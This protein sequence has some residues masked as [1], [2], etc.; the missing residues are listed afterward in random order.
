VNVNK[1]LTR[2][3]V[4]MDTWSSGKNKPNSN[5]IKDN[6]MPKQTQYKPKQS[7]FQRQKNRF[8]LT[9]Q[10]FFYSMDVLETTIYNRLLFSS[11]TKRNRRFHGKNGATED[12]DD[13]IGISKL[14]TAMR[15]GRVI[16]WEIV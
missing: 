6:K 14:K 7:Q 9:K 15:F 8:L 1:V 3:Y 12:A 11:L 13:I 2:D 4:Q 10:A 16:F 5:P